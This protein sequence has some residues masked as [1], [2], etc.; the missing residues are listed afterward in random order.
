MGDLAGLVARV[1]VGDG[2][3]CAGHHQDRVV[4]VRGSDGVAVQAKINVVLARPGV[5]ASHVA[6][7]VVIAVGADLVQGRDGNPGKR[8]PMAVVVAAVLATRAVLMRCQAQVAA[9]IGL[10]HVRVVVDKEVVGG[11]RV[12]DAGHDHGARL[13]RGQRD[14]DAGVSTQLADGRDGLAAD[15]VDVARCVVLVGVARDLRVSANLEVGAVVVHSGTTARASDGIA[16]DLAAGHNEGAAVADAG[17]VA[18]SLVVL[19]AAAGHG[20]SAG[21]A[22]AGTVARDGIVANGAAP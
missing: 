8:R 9:A 7:Q 20:E 4:A 3:V 16:T 10:D 12:A 13:V 11:A 18:D 2:Q 5:R 21:I 17:A 14:A 6:G 22:H 15:K 19:D 1:A